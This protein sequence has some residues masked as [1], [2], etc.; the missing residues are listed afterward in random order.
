MTRVTEIND[1]R[2]NPKGILLPVAYFLLAV[3]ILYAFGKFPSSSTPER[4]PYSEFLH[5]LDQSKIQE[6]VLNEH[7]LT[8]TRR[9][10]KPEDGLLKFV[11]IVFDDPGLVQKLES[12]GVVFSRE[13]SNSGFLDIWI[14]VVPLLLSALLWSFFIRGASKGMQGGLL[15]VTK[16]KAKAY[17]E[18]NIKTTFADVAGV[19][20]AKVELAEVVQFLKEPA[21]YARLGGHIPKGVLLV[22]PPG[23]GKTLLARAIAGE[24]NVPFFSINGSEFVEL[25]VGVGAARVRDLFEQA[26][27]SAPCILFI[28]EIDALGKSRA[29][30]HVSFSSN[31]EKE[32]TLNQLLA[33]MDGFDPR[34][35]VILLAA[36]NRPEI[37]DPALLRAG[38]F[39]RQVLVSLPDQAGRAEILKVHIKKIKI[40]DKF[41]PARIAALT[42]G[43]SGADLANVVNE[44]ALFA[45]RRDA[46]FVAEDDFTQAI[47]RIVAGLE[48]R[49]KIINPVEKNR[50]AYHEMGHATVALALGTDEKVHKVSIIPR[51]I[52]ALGYT[53]RRPTEDR[54]IQNED[55]LL[56]KIAVLLGGRAAEK[57][58]FNKASTA[59]VDDLVKANDLAK[60]M[61]TR[62]AMSAQLGLA[63][64]DRDPSPFL[65]ME[66]GIHSFAGSSE[67]T[68]QLVDQEVRSILDKAY[69]LAVGAV[70]KN[71]AFIQAGAQ[72]LLAIET[73]NDDKIL[74]LWNSHA[75]HQ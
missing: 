24:A 23:T 58:F 4:I 9:I 7:V 60:A 47:E 38:R 74:A 11:T 13:I 70:E 51:G 21:H 61:V 52:G 2:P 53:L 26:S 19:D 73:L 69:V 37:L 30:N 16:S 67:A 43:F 48:Q 1:K 34:E 25:F 31:D 44:A 59:A 10:D 56:T 14:W 33:E 72:E 66:S 46:D 49:K 6:V 55:E 63:V 40:D 41:D 8:G 27:K 15:S 18:R 64:Y 57:V 12:K 54:Y 50:T 68:A 45:T 75:Q 35:G 32:Q 22:G 3:S 62:F 36:T 17:M 71:R 65:R 42:P 39:D 20:E 29:G 5:Y 28:D